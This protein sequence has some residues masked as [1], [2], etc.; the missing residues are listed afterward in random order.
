MTGQIEL[1]E[2]NAKLAAYKHLA[3]IGL[4]KDYLEKCEQ[5]FET[6]DIFWRGVPAYPEDAARALSGLSSRTNA[7]LSKRS[8][9]RKET[10]SLE[11]L[12]S[13]LMVLRIPSILE[14]RVTNDYKGTF[15]LLLGT[16]WR[17]SERLVENI[18]KREPEETVTSELIAAYI[19]TAPI[20]RFRVK[21]NK[22][23]KGEFE[24]YAP[25]FR[26]WLSYHVGWL[27]E[28]ENR[29]DSLDEPIGR[30]ENGDKKITLAELTPDPKADKEIIFGAEKKFI[31][32]LLT[33]LSPKEHAAVTKYMDDKKLSRTENKAMNRGMA[34]VRAYCEE[35]GIEKPAFII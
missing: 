6:G 24:P 16:V 4:P 15:A 9:D 35:R 5:D 7:V 11:E 3:T 23:H 21:F 17:G 8:S 20:E 30:N 27:V 2:H 25:A 32:G 33:L 28:D 34:R 22:K 14:W 19:L 13:M 26:T 10:A 31:A 29:N 1:G 12:G 18:V